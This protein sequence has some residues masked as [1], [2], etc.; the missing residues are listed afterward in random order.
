ML[1]FST[2]SSSVPSYFFLLL[3]LFLCA[4]AVCLL[5]QVRSFII[6]L[7]SEGKQDA[8]CCCY[9]SSEAGSRVSML[10]MD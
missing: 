4:P 8:L 9:V 6:A 7:L 2:S 10:D 1:S 5:T 3:S